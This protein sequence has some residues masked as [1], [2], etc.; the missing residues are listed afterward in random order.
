MPV[1]LPP[2]LVL[3]IERSGA[4][5]L[6]QVTAWREAL[7]AYPG[8]G[9]IAYVWAGGHAVPAGMDV[10][11]PGAAASVL[12]L[13]G[14]SVAVVAESAA[15]PGHHLLR[16]L[17]EEA[18]VAPDR[19]VDA[20]LLPVELTRVS[21]RPRGYHLVDDTDPTAAVLREARYPGSDPAELDEDDDDEDEDDGEDEDDDE[22]DREEEDN[23]ARDDSGEAPRAAAV[24]GVVPPVDHG[25]P[26]HGGAGESDQDLR[27]HDGSVLHARVTGVC[28]AVR[29]RDLPALDH[30]LMALPSATSG[31]GLLTAAGSRHLDVVVA[32]TAAVSLPVR[33]AWDARVDG[34]VTGAAERS[35]EWS[36]STHPVDLPSSSLGAMA[37]QFALRAAD[38]PLAEEASGAPFLSIVTRTQGRR[39]H[40]LEDLLTC[41]AGQEDRDF[42]LLVM[43]HRVSAVEVGA[44]RDVVASSPSWLHDQVR[45]LEVE[46]PGRASPLNDGFAAAHGR[47]IVAL[48]DDDTVLAH[49]V[50]TFKAAAAEHDGRVLRTVAVRQDVAP[51][52]ASTPCA[53][54]RSTTRSAS[55]RWTSA[56][57]TTWSPTTAPS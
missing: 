36:E 34:F 11:S 38:R 33:L 24:A 31:E 2:V 47:Y 48:D 10:A 3:L 25:D 52:A 43:C 41:L 54:S 12:G 13:P 56:S 55:G 23:E 19:V 4:P 50:A 49:Y 8:G 32:D 6:R 53:R 18:L 27:A 1:V 28:C 7:A 39:L 17:V 37:R 42:E 5:T 29:A 22:D 40:C 46:R 57:S 30:A 21:D 20:R 15:V 16:R 45:M 9:E 14:D 51:S 44:V 35:V 26:G